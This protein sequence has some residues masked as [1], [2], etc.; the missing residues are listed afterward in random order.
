MKNPYTTSNTSFSKN[1]SEERCYGFL[2]D[3][4]G[5]EI[6]ITEH[7]INLSCLELQDDQF[8]PDALLPQ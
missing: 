7:M 1:S 8:Y 5:R 3:D 4:S 2:I 6:P